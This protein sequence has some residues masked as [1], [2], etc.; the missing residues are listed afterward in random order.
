MPAQPIRISGMPLGSRLLWSVAWNR[1]AVYIVAVIIGTLSAINFNSP[2]GLLAGM[3]P[4]ITLYKAVAFVNE[5]APE[6]ISTAKEMSLRAGS[7][8]VGVPIESATTFSLARPEGLS[9]LGITAA[10]AYTFVCIYL[11]EDYFAIFSGST[12][13]LP[14]QRLEPA[15][16]GEEIYFRH[17]TAV[18]Q[19]NGSIELT[20]GRG[21]KTKRI[22]T[23]SDPQS[24][25]LIEQLRCRLRTHQVATTPESPIQLVP[26]LPAPPAPLAAL[27]TSA[28]SSERYC[29]LRIDK[30]REYYADPVVIDALML[31]LEVPG[32]VATHKAM[33]IQQKQAA[34]EA[35]ADHFSRTPTS[36][37]HR[38]PRQEI[39]AASL[40]RCRGDILSERVVM[41]R[42]YEVAREEDLRRPVGRWLIDRGD[43]PYMEIQLGR[44]RIDALGYNKG[45]QRLTA[46][47]LKNSDAEFRRGPDQMGSFTEYAHTVYLACTPAF[48]ADYLERN[49]DHRA[50]N[51]WDPT[52]LDRKLKQG[53]FGLLIVERDKVFEIISPVE[54]T[55]PPERVAKVIAGLAAFHKIDLD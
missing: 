18:N 48:A 4:L 54:Q 8:R 3:I 51:H 1:R 2:Y 46:V 29:Y 42:F 37:W 13:S 38:I 10:P 16:G 35:Q 5:T 27:P 17:V 40:W 12:L 23:G 55:P 14:E 52:L 7:Q 6:L 45:T 25:A 33:T 28:T 39:L 22:E 44:R 50:V 31:Q 49:A 24:G 36:F 47:E 11:T 34:I 43:E 15:E 32:T 41:D 19:T 26:E 21:Q 20:L 30:L 53:G 9:P